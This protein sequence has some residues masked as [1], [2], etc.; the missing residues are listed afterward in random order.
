LAESFKPSCYEMYKT[1]SRILQV[2]LMYGDDVKPAYKAALE[3]FIAELKALNR[4]PLRMMNASALDR[5]CTYVKA[6]SRRVEE[7]RTRF[8]DDDNGLIASLSQKIEELSTTNMRPQRGCPKAY[9]FPVP[10][11]VG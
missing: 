4:D 10:Q 8:P 1:L 2:P 9:S 5:D 6:V 11:P 3:E 7:W